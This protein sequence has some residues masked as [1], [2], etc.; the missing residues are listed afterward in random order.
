MLEASRRDGAPPEWLTAVDDLAFT[1][2]RPH[3][4]MGVYQVDGVNYPAAIYG[5]LEGWPAPA[6]QQKKFNDRLTVIGKEFR[7]LAHLF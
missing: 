4:D 5:T 3:F 6:S 1:N 2:D 7:H